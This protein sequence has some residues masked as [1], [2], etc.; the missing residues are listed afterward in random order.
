[1][2]VLEFLKTAASKAGLVKVE[3]APAPDAAPVPSEQV[4]TTRT[5]ALSDLSQELSRQQT[6]E[7]AVRAP[8]LSL[9]FKNLFSSITPK[10]PLHGWGI[11]SVLNF[12][13]AHG[14][15]PEKEK[16][17]SLMQAL[18][19]EK[20]T[21]EEVLKD[22]VLMDKT[23]DAYECFIQKKHQQRCDDRKRQEEKLHQRI[24]EVQQEIETLKQSGQ[25]DKKSVEQWL[26]EKV[27]MEQTLVN[28]AKLLTKESI[29]TVG[30]VSN[31]PRS[32][33]GNKHASGFDNKIEQN[34]IEKP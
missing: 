4:I 26:K 22:A 8:E 30:N 32:I 13:E 17:D 14:E 31:A 25:S 27:S 6:Q 28:A 15:Q 3:A 18:S 16:K 5:V 2:K 24:S 12:L 9:D 33:S 11:V 21:A 1:M 19:V 29:I 7:I 10:A 34:K 20:V 23:L